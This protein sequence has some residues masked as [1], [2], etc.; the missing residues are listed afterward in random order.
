[1]ACGTCPA[2]ACDDFPCKEG[3]VCE[4]IESDP[5]KYSDSETYGCICGESGFTGKKCDE[6]FR[7]CNEEPCGSAAIYPNGGGRCRDSVRPVTAY[8]L[9]RHTLLTR[10]LQSSF[11]LL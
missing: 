11:V 6:D 8:F 7:E 3:S 4:D 1:M 9:G 2:R 10:V 5:D